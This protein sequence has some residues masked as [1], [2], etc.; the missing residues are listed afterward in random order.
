[1]NEK[2]ISK[3]KPAYP[4]TNMLSNYLTAQGRNIKIPI[5]YDDL[6]RF[7]GAVEIFDDN[8]NDTLWISCY[9]AE[10]ERQEI[11]LSLKQ[12][13][14]ILHSDG[15]DTILPYL[16]IDSIDFC[17][18]GNTKPFRIKVRNI[19]NDNYIFLYLKRADASRI[20]GLE[21]EHLLSP[22]H[23]NFLVH[24]DTLIE[25]H[26]SGIPGDT[27]IKEHLDKISEQDK[28]ALAKEF[29]KFNE[30]CF[31]RLLADM[32]SYN[33][34]IV[35]THDF[36]RIQYRIRAV[37]FDQQS[38]EGNPK[39]YKPQ[40]LKE[41]NALVEMSLKVL[42]SES[43]EQYEKEERSLLAKRAT[44]ENERLLDLV[45]CMKKDTISSPDKIKELKTGLYQ[46]TG[47]VNFKKSKNMG[48]LL[49]AAL[50]FIIR[51]YQSENPYIIK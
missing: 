32:R 45:K 25:E 22:N 38:Y 49:N 37:D 21:L 47:D 6:L 31:V 50:D 39:V 24:K 7:Q 18:F 41:N 33:Y 29:V 36:D 30:R 15:S 1:M 28:R 42:A 11:E 40:F 44:S 27:F 10:H 9:Y 5:F 20:Y 34:V 26:I 35:I 14:S 19:L 3:K 51:N 43:I 12:M 46:L 23:I 2:L 16:N 48:M 4:I 13:Y 17:T 8:D